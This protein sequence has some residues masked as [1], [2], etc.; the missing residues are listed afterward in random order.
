MEFP[1]I[2]TKNITVYVY[3]VVEDE[4]SFLNTYSDSV[5]RIKDIEDIENTGDGFFLA[6]AAAATDFVYISP[7]PIAAEFQTY[8]RSLLKYNH[9]SIITP[10]GTTHQLCLDLIK[11]RGSFRQLI[12]LL[13]LYRQVTLLAYSA[14]PQFYQ[15]KAALER[16][17]VPVRTPEAP[18]LDSAWTV[19]FFGSKSGIRQLA[20]L[21]MPNGLICS[22]R[23][24]ASR[25]AAHK[26]LKNHGV[27]IKTNKGS[28]GNGILIFRKNDLPGNYPACVNKLESILGREHYWE[29]FPVVVEDLVKVNSALGGGFPSIEF[30]I[31][32]NGRIEMLFHGILAVTDKGKYYG[33]DVN[34]SILPNRLKTQLLDIGYYLACQFSAAGYRG[35]FDI[36]M[37]A[38]KNSRLY[39]SESNTRN[40][41]WT[42]IYKIVKKL[43]GRDWF[44]R[45]YVLNR[46][47]FRLKK[48]RWTSLGNLLTGLS[49]LLYSPP[50]KKGIIINSES[51]LK[52]KYLYYTII[53]PDKKTAYAYQEKMMTLLGNQP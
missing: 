24:E 30:K 10:K 27:V 32:T 34:S 8:A 36:D 42:D 37:I 25:I 29:K 46:E 40:T 48:N 9:G 22:G 21:V 26:Y 20:G 19:N 4:W 16:A 17:G 7:K 3:N 15:L 47:Y 31:K 14:T 5:R 13:A 18:D 53:A 11:D 43:V 41:G 52:S 1:A 49:P 39:V 44:N 50:T 38:A 2:K 35:H 33:M 23:I 45:V 28:G 12:A 6:T 51:F